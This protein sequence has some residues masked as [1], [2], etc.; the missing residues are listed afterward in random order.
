M[1]NID[2]LTED[3]ILSENQKFVCLSF[4]SESNK[5]TNTDDVKEQ[6]DPIKKSTLIGIKVR[7]VFPTYEAACAHAKT[8]QSIDPY[9]NVFV[10]DM[11]KWLPFDPNPDTIKEAEYANEQLNTMMKSYLENQEKAKIYHEHRKN[12]LIRKN[13]LENLTSRHEN[14]KEVKKKIKKT[15]DNDEK[16]TLEAN[17]K[18]IEDQIKIM[19]DKKTELDT[20]INELTEQIKAFTSSPMVTSAPKIID[21]EI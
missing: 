18:S 14:L 6:D 17:A 12:D 21:M 2:Y 13:I 7:G 15:E 4:L 16:Q 19:D 3:N 8:L 11:G 9:F 1:A 5:H 10:G 20:Q